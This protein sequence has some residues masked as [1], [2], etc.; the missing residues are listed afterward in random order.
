MESDNRYRARAADMMVEIIWKA[1][2]L[3]YSGGDGA[4]LTRRDQDLPGLRLWHVRA[5]T[6]MGQLASICLE[7]VPDSELPELMEDLEKQFSSMMAD[8]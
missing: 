8:E 1:G 5:D 3:V 6:I 4:P 2:T 7:E